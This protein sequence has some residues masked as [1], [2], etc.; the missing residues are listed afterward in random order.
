[1]QREAMSVDYESTRE[2]DPKKWAVTSAAMSSTIPL[3][4]CIIAKCTL[5]QIESASSYQ[6][7][8]YSTEYQSL[9]LL[10]HVPTSISGPLASGG[11]GIHR[12][13]RTQAC[14]LLRI[15]CGTGAL[16]GCCLCVAADGTNRLTG[17]APV[18]RALFGCEAGTSET[19]T[20]VRSKISPASKRWGKR[21]RR[22]RSSVGW[23]T[24]GRHL[25]GMGV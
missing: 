1:M 23:Q 10:R 17:A 22:G 19:E 9:S 11:S 3:Q 5:K 15:V 21:A 24:H 14:A 18:R 16:I 8:Q 12:D 7:T 13:K 6:S 4:V 20:F 2:D 25:D